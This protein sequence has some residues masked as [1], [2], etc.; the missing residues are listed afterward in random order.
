M[1]QLRFVTLARIV[2]GLI[3]A[4]H[5][6]EII[7]QQHSVPEECD[8]L[9]FDRIAVQLFPDFSRARLQTWIKSGAL[10]V[11]SKRR[12][13]SDTLASGMLLRL[14]AELEQHNEWQA[15][16][17]ALEIVHEDAAI[18]VVNKPA[19]L[20]V[21][22]GAGQPSGTL[23]NALLHH[24]DELAAVPRAGIVHRLDK[25]TSGLLVI[26]KTLSAHQQLVQQLQQRSVKR[27]YV[28]IVHGSPPAKGSVDAALGRHPVQRTKMAVQ[29]SGGKPAITHFNTLRRFAAVSHVGLK[30]E[31]GRT[32]QIRVHMASIGHALIGDPVYGAKLRGGANIDAE[33]RSLLTNFPRQAL[34]ARRLG[35]VHPLSGKLCQWQAP[36]PADI[37]GLLSALEGY[38]AHD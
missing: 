31:T 16:A 1:D 23:A 35:L 32:H 19:G 18:I 25:D 4:Q 15:E 9:R 3:S 34:H 11:D 10:Q 17:I 8:G 20:V 12:K 26:A 29:K 5:M 28:A 13:P 33:L 21:H 36:L 24:C 37:A 7:Q 38:E 2:P 22:P 27:E 30:L 14:H 6:I